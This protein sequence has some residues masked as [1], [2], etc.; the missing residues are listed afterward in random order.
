M[1]TLLIA[2]LIGI[3]SATIFLILIDAESPVKVP[4]FHYRKS[5]VSW[6][7]KWCFKSDFISSTIRRLKKSWELS[8]SNICR[9]AK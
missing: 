7:T 5:I 8:I 6:F 9:L 1:L 3:I 4:L 2:A